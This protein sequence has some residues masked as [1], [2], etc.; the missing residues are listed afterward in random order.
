MYRAFASTFWK[1]Q[2]QTAFRNS[3]KGYTRFY[4]QES[5]LKGTPSFT[6]VKS[7][8]EPRTRKDP[9]IENE[10]KEWEDHRERM[11]RA[12]TGMSIFLGSFTLA[13]FGG[14]IFYYAFTLYL[15]RQ[16]WP[17]HEEVIGFTNKNLLYI[18]CYY[19][20]YAFKYDKALAVLRAALERIERQ[21]NISGDSYVVLDTKL[22]IATCLFNLEKHQ[23]AEEMLTGLLPTLQGLSKSGKIKDNGISNYIHF[24]GA[25]EEDGFTIYYSAVDD[26]IYKTAYLLAQIYAQRGQLDD[27]KTVSS[28]GIQAIKRIKKSIASTFT[29][30][31]S[32]NYHFIDITNEKEALITTTLAEA[33]YEA[34]ERQIAETLFLGVVAAVKQHWAHYDTTHP[35]SV[36]RRMYSQ[37]WECLDS[38]AMLYLARLKTDAKRI[39]EAKS[40]MESA[41]KSAMHKY[42][43]E[44]MR[45]INCIAGLIAQEGR[46]EE[47]NGNHTKALR[48]YR[49]AYQH[50]RINFSKYKHKLI[51]DV[52]RLEKAN[53]FNA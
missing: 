4:S 32:H 26:L 17:A 6:Q 41:R 47:L 9:Y 31:V 24:L 13:C 46:I 3:P 51:H 36:N 29:S 15:V 53:S 18:S 2:Y 30:E 23:E 35:L 40:W 10:E 1:R 11:R 16:F 48:K 19:E 43:E 44:P 34:G 25:T 14:W 45:C 38:H 33:F 42:L 12:F 39:D 27:V 20:Y 22:R 5:M 28:I 21:D 50:A 37:Q 8:K 7:K 52:K 49:D